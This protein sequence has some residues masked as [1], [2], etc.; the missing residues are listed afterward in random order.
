MNIAIVGA[1]GYGGV[2]LLRLL[3]QHYKV[4][5]I[6]LYSSSQEG[7]AM[8][9]L[10]PH[11]ASF[12]TYQL[13][14][15]TPEKMGEAHDVI[16]LST[17]P[18]VSA[19]LTVKLLNK[20]AK[21]IDLSGDLRLENQSV[22]E[23][24][25]KRT[26]APDA[27]RQQ[28]VYGLTEWNALSIQSANVVA[29]PGCYPTAS[30]LGLLP[31]ANEGILDGAS[32]IIDAKT[33]TTGAGRSPSAVTHF[34]ETNENLKAY[35]VNTHKHLP[36]MEEHLHK[37]G[38]A[39]QKLTFT[40]HLAPMARGIMATMYVQPSQELNRKDIDELY[41]AAYQ[42]EPF[43]HVHQDGRVPSTKE[44]YASNMCMIGT[45]LDE[46]TG[47]LTVVSVIDNLV[48]GAAGQAIQNMNVMFGFSQNTGIQQAPVFP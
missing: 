44:T 37:L 42:N 39:D 4:E 5:N 29:N 47:R 41:Q 16:F 13:E 48:K 6:T 21:V 46:R 19:E 25:Y 31:L 12:P 40:P 3:N 20:R 23:T 24:W 36:E 17:P 32:V 2:E 27:L 26:A 22:Y 38:G 15:V 1:T 9:E 28:A 34:S 30:L 10:Y 18:G 11:L 7:T 43:V 14:A 33:G 8:H 45:A 35:G